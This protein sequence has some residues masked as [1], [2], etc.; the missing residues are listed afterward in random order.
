MESGIGMKTG[1]EIEIDTGTGIE[2]DIGAEI[3]IVIEADM[4]TGSGMVI[5][6]ELWDMKSRQEVEKEGIE[7]MSQDEVRN[8]QE[9]GLVQAVEVVESHLYDM[10]LET[11]TLKVKG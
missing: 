9:V 10:K 5:E 3:G 11:E 7:M 8:D 1:T 6:S 2:M 4:K